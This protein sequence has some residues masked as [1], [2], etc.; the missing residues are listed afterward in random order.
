M[1]CA[2][3]RRS[4]SLLPVLR[5]VG[6]VERVVRGLEDHEHLARPIQR[7]HRLRA[8][9]EPF[10][11]RLKLIH[12]QAAERLDA[13]EALALGAQSREIGIAELYGWVPR[14]DG[15]VAQARIL[16]TERARKDEQTQSECDDSR[17]HG[18]SPMFEAEARVHLTAVAS[19]SIMRP[20][21]ASLAT[22]SNV[23]EGCDAA[24]ANRL[25]K[26]SP[27]SRNASTSVV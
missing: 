9:V 26:T 17:S 24:A 19:I 1:S 18:L 27:A 11:V 8:D 25:P 15:R 16:L 2:A 21:N 6:G 13:G 7:E 3:R 4:A 20:G 5:R 23:P 14:D 10:D 22:P 12:R